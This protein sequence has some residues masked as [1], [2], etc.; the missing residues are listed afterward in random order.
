MDWQHR[1]YFFKATHHSLEVYVKLV[2]FTQHLYRLG[3]YLTGNNVLQK[4]TPA[5]TTTKKRKTTNNKNNNNN[6]TEQRQRRY[7]PML[8]KFVV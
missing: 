3:Q 4:K 5:A 2:T 8:L 6:K 1:R 7:L